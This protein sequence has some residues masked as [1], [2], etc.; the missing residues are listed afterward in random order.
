MKY[1]Q[2]VLI[3]CVVTA[4]LPL[5]WGCA[6]LGQDEVELP[7]DGEPRDYPEVP[8]DYPYPVSWLLPEERKLQIPSLIFENMVL[9]DRA[10]IKLWKSGDHSF[11]GASLTNEIFFPKYP[12]VVYVYWEEH[13]KPD[14]TIYRV[15]HKIV[16]SGR[17]DDDTIIDQ[18]NNGEIPEGI[19]IVDAKEVGIDINEFLSNSYQGLEFHNHILKNGQNYDIENMKTP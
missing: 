5:M 16:T 19:K 9:L 18:L 2:G 8:D 11:S 17:N 14:G 10:Q 13:E 12:G 7:M 15:V 3:V 1:L 6:P 4:V